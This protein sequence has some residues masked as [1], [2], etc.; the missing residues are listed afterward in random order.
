[1]N[2]KILIKIFKKDIMNKKK[3][4]NKIYIC[5]ISFYLDFNNN[6]KLNYNN[7][8]KI[9]KKIKIYLIKKSKNQVFLFKLDFL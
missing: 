2:F 5:N 4:N 9:K 8:K 3:L 1:M 7:I 6:A